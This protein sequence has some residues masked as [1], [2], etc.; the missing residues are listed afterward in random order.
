MTYG[1]VELDDAV[2]R[3]V[4]EKAFAGR[5]LPNTRQIRQVIKRSCHH[6][7]QVCATKVLRCA[8][9]RDL[10]PLSRVQCRRRHVQLLLKRGPAPENV[11]LDGGARSSPR[12][13]TAHP[14]NRRASPYRSANIW[15]HG[16]VASAAILKTCMVVLSRLEYV[17]LSLVVQA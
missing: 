13:H 16:S 10:R 9:E 6:C 3:H 2:V 5:L 8:K 15:L 11:S 17:G 1:K 7:K 12:L 14:R 4:L